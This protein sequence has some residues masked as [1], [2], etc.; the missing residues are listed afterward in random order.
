MMFK[1]DERIKTIADHYGFSN[2]SIKI[3]EEMDE[4]Q[5]VI[6][7]YKYGYYESGHRFLLDLIEETVDVEIMIEQLKYLVTKGYL[8]REDM[9]W[10]IRNEKLDRQL[11]RI[12]KEKEDKKDVC[13]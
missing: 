6:K 7:R 9:Y 11:K 3:L 1:L 12:E 2:Q 10:C 4:L 5:E 13:A 8:G